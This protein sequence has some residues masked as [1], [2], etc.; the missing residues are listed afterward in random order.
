MNVVV[1][2]VL[3]AAIPY[4][5]WSISPTQ[6]PAHFSMWNSRH[7]RPMR[8][9]WLYLCCEHVRIGNVR[10]SRSSVSRMAYAWPYGP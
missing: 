7:G 5:A 4:A 8:A 2:M 1:L 10:S 3:A 9:W 6:G